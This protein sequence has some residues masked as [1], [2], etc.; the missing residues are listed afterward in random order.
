M[1][2]LNLALSTAF[3]LTASLSAVHAAGSDTPSTPA[4]TCKK[5]EVY[6]T[7]KKKCVKQTSE[8]IPDRS[9]KAQGWALARSGQYEVAIELFQL[10]ADKRDPEALN[11]LGYSHRKLGKVEQGVAFYTAALEANPDYVLAREYLGEGYVK[12]GQLDK[13]REQLAE[14]GKRCGTACEEYM[15]LATAID[16][17]KP[18]Y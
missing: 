10:V 14:I 17:G 5:G 8:I 18:I 6:S 4:K 16:T 7:S 12:L 15:L 1:K 2:I 3:L 13:A 9:L 11:G